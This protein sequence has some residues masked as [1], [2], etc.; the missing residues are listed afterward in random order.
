[1]LRV[2]VEIVPYGLESCKRNIYTLEIINT[3]IEGVIIN[4]NGEERY[5]Y[6]VRTKDENGAEEDHGVLVENFDRE[7]HAHELIKLV[8][9]KLEEKGFFTK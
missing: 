7:K 1:M 9:E 4:E 8:T 5:S 6:R 3:G 2:S